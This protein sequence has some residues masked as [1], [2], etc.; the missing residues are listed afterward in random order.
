MLNNIACLTSGG[1][2]PGMN[3]CI[4]ALVKHARQRNLSVWGIQG[5]FEGIFNGRF[6]SLT[7]EETARFVHQGG[8]FLG[9][10]RYLPFQDQ[11]VQRKAID[12][13]SKHDISGLIILGGDGSFRGARALHRLGFISAGIPA[14]IDNNIAGSDYTLGHDTACNQMITVIDGIHD[15]GMSMP[16]RIFLVETLGGDSS[17]L[18]QAAARAGLTDLILCPDQELSM[19]DLV[20]KIKT[21]FESGLAYGLVIIAEGCGGIEEKAQFIQDNIGQRVRITRMGHFQRGGSP[22][23]FDRLFSNQAAELVISRITNGSSGFFAAF[24]NGK[25]VAK[26]F[27]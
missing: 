3:A 15:T 6:K 22:T 18:A 25:I 7:M 10:G 27:L 11:D 12:I 20:K 2:A 4:H 24:E 19:A 26:Q 14:T 9:T 5:G 17:F 8:S 13:L 1:D 21:Q 16:G 23:Y